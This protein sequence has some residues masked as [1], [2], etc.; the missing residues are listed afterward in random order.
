MPLPLTARRIIGRFFQRKFSESCKKVGGHSFQDYFR[1][2]S[3]IRYSIKNRCPI[4]R[5]HNS[6]STF[7]IYLSSLDSG[8]WSLAI[9]HPLDES[10]VLTQLHQ[11]IH[12]FDIP[13]AQSAFVSKDGQTFVFLGM[14]LLQFQ[15]T[16]DGA[17]AFQFR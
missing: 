6:D 5:D 1:C 10:L 9:L 13:F 8:H 11:S 4:R 17:Q 2:K 3:L 16:V 14:A 12:G 7:L 15:I